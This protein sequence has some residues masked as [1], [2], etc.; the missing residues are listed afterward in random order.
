MNAQRGFTL[1][2]LLVVIAVIGILAAIAVP[3]YANVQQRARIA[4]AQS[5]S[6]ALAT[7]ASIYGAHMGHLPSALTDLTALATNAQNQVAGPFMAS[8][9]AAPSGWSAYAYSA[10]TGVGVFTISATG[11]STSVRVP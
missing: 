10:D 3:L 1:I 4:K 11:D 2:E 6:R 9:P 7:A 5:D 8:I